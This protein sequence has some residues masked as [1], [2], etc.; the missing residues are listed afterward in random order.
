ML[1]PG[2]FFSKASAIYRVHPH[3][4]IISQSVISLALSHWWLAFPPPEN[5]GENLRLPLYSWNMLMIAGGG[6]S[7]SPVKLERWTV[8]ASWASSKFISYGIYLKMPSLSPQACCYKSQMPVKT[9]GCLS[10][11]FR[12]I[13]YKLGF[14]QSLPRVQ[15][16]CC[17]DTQNS[18]EALIYKF[19]TKDIYYKGSWWNTGWGV[20]PSP[21]TPPSRSLQVAGCSGSSPH[22]VLWDF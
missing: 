17:K 18:G 9:P 11:G 19:I 10:Q 14:L 13:S 15:L 5:V 7:F 3:D 12:V 16:L 6:S 1:G 4:R 8:N 22:V 20:G 21:G 2:S